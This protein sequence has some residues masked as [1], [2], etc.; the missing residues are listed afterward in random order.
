MPAN[1][2]RF[3]SVKKALSSTSLAVGIL[4]MAGCQAETVLNPNTPTVAGVDA[5]VRIAMQIRASGAM[6]LQRALM[7]G[8]VS[9]TGILGRESFNYTATEA[10]N[11]TEFLR[12]AALTNA[13]FVAGG[14]WAARYQDML[15][16]KQMSDLTDQTTGN[17]L[18]P[19]E[20]SAA[21]CLMA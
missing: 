10:R 17:T 19:A 2:T 14:Q 3:L 15:G 6:A 7:P 16:L 20:R 18:T 8:F 1:S 11:T 9:A 12:T 13:S 21:N 5:D 4:L